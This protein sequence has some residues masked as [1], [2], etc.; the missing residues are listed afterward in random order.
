[1]SSPCPEPEQL[2]AFVLGK[3]PEEASDAIAAHLDHCPACESTI[4]GMDRMNDT[5]VSQLCVPA[6]QSKYI[7]EPQCR[8]ALQRVKAMA[9]AAVAPE[10]S[11]ITVAVAPGGGGG[12]P[13][14]GL[15]RLGEYE[16]LAKLGEGG[17]GAVYKARQTRLDKI[18]AIKVLPKHRMADPQARA[19]FEREMR[20]VGRVSHPNIIQALDARDIEGTTV[21]VMEYAKGLDLGEVVHRCARLGVADAC[22]IV[23]Q[24]ALGLEAVHEN[25]LVHRDIKPSNLMLTTL[26]SPVLGRG[27][28]GEGVPGY[29]SA[30]IKIL[31]LG[32]ARLGT[33]LPGSGELTS[34]GQA[35]GTAD[36][37]APEQ[38]TDSHT[39]DIRADIYSLGCTLY[40][41][42]A[43]HAPF[44]G[45]D[46]D[47]AMKKMIANTQQPVPPLGQM[48]SDVPKTLLKVL[49]RML[50]KKP[51]ERFATPAEVAAAIAPFAKGADLPRL[52]KEAEEAGYAAA[53]GDRAPRPPSRTHLPASSA[54]IRTGRREKGRRGGG[55]RAR[56]EAEGVRCSPRPYSGEGQGVRAAG[57]CL[58]LQPVSRW[59]WWAAASGF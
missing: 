17:M 21:L 42:L 19:R 50:A 39:V 11:G 30:T 1:M 36:Y 51:D 56:K 15:G 13:D 27:A 8:E 18:V 29:G 33:E 48:R 4:S 12:E 55:E 5:L 47:N 9:G 35:M 23:H 34:E 7:E 43:G 38:V 41:L 44:S 45:P 52:L 14:G 26:P 59:C 2:R 32:L 6:A 16:L 53:K 58:G 57:I 3:L 40:K 22:S 10:P 49:D 24:A 37:M 46:Y 54:P 20:A 31:D 28:G 25:G